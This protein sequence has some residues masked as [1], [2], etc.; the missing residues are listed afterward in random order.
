MNIRIFKL[1]RAE[2]IATVVFMG[3][4]GIISERRFPAAMRDRDI[5]NALAGSTG[6]PAPA[7]APREE[8]PAPVTPPP[9]EKR[10]DVRADRDEK[11]TLK[12]QYLADLAAAGID[13]AKERS[14]AKIETAWKKHCAGGDHA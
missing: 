8:K 12:K 3:A 6:E 9:E 14:F 10:K 11:R 4:D 7:P 1:S 13:M 5:L 2:G